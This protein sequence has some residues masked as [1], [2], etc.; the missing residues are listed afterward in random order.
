ML[1]QQTKNNYLP[2]CPLWVLWQT[3]AFR[4]PPPKKIHMLFHEMALI[5]VRHWIGSL[6]LTLLLWHISDINWKCEVELS[7]VN[8][9]ITFGM[10]DPSST[11][12]PICSFLIWLIYMFSIEYRSIANYIRM[13]ENDEVELSVFL[14]I[15]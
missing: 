7:T 8:A 15:S 5:Y 14:Y 4:I 13:L 10:H 6:L 9:M 11:K 12:K 3:L 1:L 2:N